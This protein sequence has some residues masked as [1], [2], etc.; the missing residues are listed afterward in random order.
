MATRG[1][2]H[3]SVG[4]PERCGNRAGVWGRITLNCGVQ[5]QKGWREV[6]GLELA[7]CQIQPCPVPGNPNPG[8][9]S[10]GRGNISEPSSGPRPAE[11]RRGFQRGEAGRGPCAGSRL[12]TAHS[13]SGGRLGHSFPW[14][15]LGPR[16]RGSSWAWGR[17]FGCHTWARAAQPHLDEGALW[18]HCGRRQLQISRRLRDQGTQP[19]GNATWLSPV[20]T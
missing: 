8:A 15:I 12:I 16:G 6:P 2:G 4:S 3:R 10:D 19:C 17:A 5:E 18:N 14:S 11:V 20:L 1:R 9:S 13:E 7:S